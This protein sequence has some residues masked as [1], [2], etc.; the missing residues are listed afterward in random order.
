MRRS[1]NSYQS[2]PF[3]DSAAGAVASA[4]KRGGFIA[5]DWGEIIAEEAVD[6]LLDVAMA[7]ARMRQRSLQLFPIEFV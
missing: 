4:A 1:V 5:L 6:L 7:R 3:E 2:N